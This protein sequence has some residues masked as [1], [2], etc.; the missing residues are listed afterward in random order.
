MT[1]DRSARFRD[2][3]EACE[4][5]A[6]TGS[7][8][9][10][11]RRVAEYL[12]TL[13]DQDLARACTFL[14]GRAL[15]PGDPLVPGVG[16][17][18][19]SKVVRELAAGDDFFAPRRRKS[20]N[21]GAA[22]RRFGD[23]GDAAEFLLNERAE[24]RGV[25]L[26]EVARCFREVAAASGPRSKARRL[27]LLL[28]RC[29][30]LEVKYALKIL[31]GDLR[32]GAKEGLLEAAVAEAF[33]RPLEDVRRANLYLGDVGQVARMAL[34]GGL[35]EVAF[36][37]FHPI[38]FM[39]ASAVGNVDE[40]QNP[41]VERWMVEDKYDGMRAQ[42]HKQGDTLRIFS[43]TREDVHEQF[44]DLVKPLLALRGA[45]LLDGEI[46]AGTR[47]RLLGFGIL[48]RR[49]GR[50]RIAPAV[51]KQYPCRYV[52]FDL[53]YYDGEAI[54]DAPLA[55][56][57]ARL[58][59]LITGGGI[60]L[61]TLHWANELAGFEPLF[62]AAR[63]RGSE[64][65]VAKDPN[66][67]YSPGRRGK[68][69]R[70]LKRP[71]ETLDCVVVAAEYGHGKRH[72]VLSDYTFAVRD[73]DRLVTITK[74]YS[75]LTDEEIDDLTRRFHKLTVARHGGVHRVQ[76]VIVMEIAFDQI[77]R[78]DRH[79]SGFALRFPRIVRTREDKRPDEI[80]TLRRVEELYR[81]A[82]R[83]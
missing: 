10:K 21:L 45:F 2:F 44:P 63:E 69:W 73:G 49:L 11:T 34:R 35:A 12:V 36:R 42:V 20:V 43:R 77:N 29:S 23:L 18:T 74:A 70:K 33:D 57:R 30:A 46:I 9:A 25:A 16:G 76:P 68:A 75:G 52:A 13:C 15:P 72:G 22:Y 6:A 80:D 27:F 31:S 40:L 61:S 48:Q 51:L 54:F 17:A 19:L 81:A 58:E 38:R 83:S 62:A 59:S 28:D 1:T 24:S 56:R 7:R 39:L 8:N 66:S 41:A 78:S 32:I 37:L 3:A 47:E 65:I 14:A 53:L 50:R 26:E 4:Q 60:D 64:G 55:E 5:I 71:M 67:P 82:G 79:T